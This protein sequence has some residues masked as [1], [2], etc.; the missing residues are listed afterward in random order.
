MTNWLNQRGGD[1]RGSARFDVVGTLCGTAV[2]DQYVRIRNIGMG[3]ALVESHGSLPLDAPV[4]LKLTFVDSLIE[5]R[6][7]HVTRLLSECY[8]IGLEFVGTGPSLLG[9]VEELIR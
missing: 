5:A 2:A 6:V 3:G 9:R 7:R 8:L 4:S 1:R